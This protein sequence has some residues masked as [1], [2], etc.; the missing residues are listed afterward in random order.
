MKQKMTKAERAI[1]KL[2][3]ISK[4]VFALNRLGKETGL[5]RKTVK[6]GREYRTMSEDVR[7][8]SSDRN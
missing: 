1:H 7:A 6:A 4:L 2:S 5:S 8:E 3:E